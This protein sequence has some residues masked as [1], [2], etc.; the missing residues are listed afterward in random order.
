MSSDNPWNTSPPPE[1]VG[2]S[3]KEAKKTEKKEPEVADDNP[4][5]TSKPKL[6]EEEA[7]AVVEKPSEKEEASAPE[8]AKPQAFVRVAGSAA[9]V[10]FLREGQRFKSGKL[11]AGSYRI[12]AKFNGV[13]DP[14][15]L[16]ADF[17]ANRKYVV[18]C[19]AAFLNCSVTPK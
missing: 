15:V 17:E 11:E 4:W 9:R 2:R 13:A 7:V 10:S 6:P 3:T 12:E 5:A 16:P 1:D 18:M 8:P 19:N 14:V